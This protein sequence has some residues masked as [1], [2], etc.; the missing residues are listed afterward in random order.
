MVRLVLPF[1]YMAC[2]VWLTPLQQAR[3][4]LILEPRLLPDWWDSRQ[5]S[6]S[7]TIA[8]ARASESSLIGGSLIQRL[9]QCPARQTEPTFCSIWAALSAIGASDKVNVQW[10][11]AHVGLEE[12]AAANQEAKRGSMLPRSSAPM[13]LTSA[14]EALK[15]HQRS[16]AEDRYLSD[17]HARVHRAFTA[18]QH[19][20]QRWQRD[21]SR[22]QCVTVAQVRSTHWPFSVGSSLPAPYRAPGLG[23]LPTLS[24]RRRNS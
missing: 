23:H 1:L 10:I 12:N 24:R 17:P 2:Y 19:C 5:C 7:R 21:W 4:C 13:D 11:P 20:Y 22:D 3:E 6:P 9:S 18:S 16:I 8:L 14:T 15:R